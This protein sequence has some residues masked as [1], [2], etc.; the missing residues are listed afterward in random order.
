[1]ALYMIG[2]IRVLEY[3]QSVTFAN[4]TCFSETIGVTCENNVSG[5][6]F[7]IAKDRNDIY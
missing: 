4:V 2:P 3:G 6:G 5:H 1:M 7:V